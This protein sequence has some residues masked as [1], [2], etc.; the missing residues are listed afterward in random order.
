MDDRP[1]IAGAGPT[2]L[3]AALFL[4]RAG[5]PVQLIDARR[6]P[7]PHS[8]ALAVNPRTLELLEPTGVTAAM[9]QHGRR[10]GGACVHR[11]GRV[12]A[13][14]P[15]DAVHPRFPFMLALSQAASERL[16]AAA[17]R[18]AGG[19]IER[20]VALRTC[21]PDGDGVGVELTAADGSVTA[22][23]APWLLG[24]DGAHSTVRQ[25]LAVAFAGDTL[26]RQ[27]HLVDVPLRTDLDPD[28]A[29]V[30]LMAGGGFR[31]LLPVLGDGEAPDRPGDAPLWRV[32]GDAEDPLAALEAD[33][34]R[35]AAAAPPVWRSSFHIAHRL[36]ASLQRGRVF[37][38]G[39]AAHLHSP[40]GAR[41]MNLGVEDAWVFAQLVRR[42]ELDRYDALRRPVDGRVVRRVRT[43]SRMAQSRSPLLR[44]GRAALLPLLL[45]VPFA[46]A[47]VARTVSGMD[48]PLPTLA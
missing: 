6:E 36:A 2:G 17:L 47:F 13:R 20:G 21:R 45:R 28:R 32:L 18:A 4:R 31:F 24:A 12:V 35:A 33:G 19:E 5:V 34:I 46:R 27:W 1:L 30:V 10:I 29:H 9:L 40:V 41:G 37:L 25:Q 7:A 39:D 43:V 38:A 42:R 44:A 8:R 23:R 14:L 11:G 26:E 48:H 3:A 16:L 15:F 22:R